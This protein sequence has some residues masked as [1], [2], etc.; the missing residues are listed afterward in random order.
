MGLEHDESIKHL[1]R[2]DQLASEHG[3]LFNLH[4]IPDVHMYY[5]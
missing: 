2:F 1:I 4:V 3:I 5:H